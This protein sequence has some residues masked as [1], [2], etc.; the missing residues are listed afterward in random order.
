MSTNKL[1]YGRVVLLGRPNAGK[2]TL[3]N[4]LI[5]QKVSITS[6]RPQTTRQNTQALF[7]NS[8][9]KIIFS[10]TP[11]IIH[12]VEDL[13]SKKINLKAPKEVNKADVLVVLFDI[14]RPKGEEENKVIAIARNSPAQKILVYNKIDIAIGVK[15]HLS[16]YNFLEDEFDITISISALKSTHTKSLISAIIEL[17]PSDYRPELKAEIE[18]IALDHSPLFGQSPQLYISEIIREKAF[19]V[20]RKELP[21][22]VYIKVDQIEDRKK[23]IFIKA[24]LLTT[25][26]RYKKMIIGK[27][28]QGIKKIGQRARRELELVSQRKIFLDLTVVADSH[29]PE[30]F[31]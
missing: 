18:S 22:S 6:P 14:S 13:V 19:L 28:A 27:G 2:S 3:I 30:T 24:R 23:L 10:D 29:W 20:L 9:A 8:Q 4:Q 12:K 1:K 17:L 26:K 7:V 15:N 11:G 16:D 31:V 25:N 21:Y 5:G